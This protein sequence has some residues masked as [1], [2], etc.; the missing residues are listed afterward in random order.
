[1]SILS[2]GVD[3]AKESFTAA[4]WF[5]QKGTFLGEFP[6]SPQGFQALEEQLSEIRRKT[7][8]PQVHLVLEPTGGYELPLAY[9]AYQ[10][11][12]RVSLPNP[13]QVRDWAK[14]MG[15]RAKTD[16]LDA[17]LLAQYG[18]ER[19]PHLWQPLPPEVAQLAELLQRRTDLEGM[20]RQEENRRQAL[21]RRPDMPKVVLENLDQVIAHL[22][23]ALQEIEKAI[24]THLEQHPQLKAQAQQL[25]TVPGIGSKLC[26]HL[27]VL[28]HRWNALTAGQGN[29]KGLVAF[30]GLDPQPYDSGATVH[31]RAVISRMGNRQ[32]QHLL[33]MGALGGV[34]G[35]NPL[36]E[37]YR[38][39]IGR[40]KAKMVALVAAARKILVWAWAVFRQHTNFCPNR[41]RARLAA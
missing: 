28:L 33:F 39:L 29:Y 19:H 36:G 32:I 26:L 11:G 14:G 18:A 22:K 25:T 37:F 3:M 7:G 2:V 27:L 30:I 31:K 20:I 35:N 41:A 1:M 6:N 23:Q 8:H 17:L 9:F 38:R 40:G 4:Y 5:A 13:K 24:Q 15:H 10:Q 21:A 34:R 16:R 12:W